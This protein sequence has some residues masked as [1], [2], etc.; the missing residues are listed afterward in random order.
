VQQQ[1]PN[2]KEEGSPRPLG[3]E[4]TAG[5]EH[6][7]F[8]KDSLSHPLQTLAELKVLQN[9]KLLVSPHV[10]ENRGADKYS[11]IAVVI[12]SKAVPDPVDPSDHAK[13][14]CRISEEVFEG[15]THDTSVGKGAMDQFQGIHW[16]KGVG[17]KEKEDLTMS[18][19][20]TGVHMSCASRMLRPE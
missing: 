17:M 4:T 8:D 6:G 2:D 10:T 12:A 11:L 7:D 19:G 13:T 18:H 20:G 15:T 5:G 3:K 1:Q 9:L 14:P 16:C